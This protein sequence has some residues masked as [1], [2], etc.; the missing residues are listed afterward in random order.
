MSNV[1]LLSIKPEYARKIFKGKKIYELRTQLPKK[2]FEKVYVY[3][4]A[5]VQKVV[6]YFT[7]DRIIRGEDKDWFWN[8]WEDESI[9][10]RYTGVTKDQYLDYFKKRQTVNAIV[11]KHLSL[12]KT[13]KLI[14]DYVKRPPQNF[15][16][17]S[18]EKDVLGQ[19]VKSFKNQ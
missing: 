14:T 8:Q 2:D 17:L 13:P 16:Y 5:P 18:Q 10:E 19:F 7:V 3:V 4:S 12:F 6:G 11:V 15:C 9:I 1:I